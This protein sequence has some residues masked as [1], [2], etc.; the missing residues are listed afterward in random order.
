M[1]DEA[2]FRQTNGSETALKYT[3]RSLLHIVSSEFHYAACDTSNGAFAS[4][5]KRGRVSR[6]CGSVVAESIRI[7]ALHRTAVDPT[8]YHK[9]RV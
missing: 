4:C 8:P 7:G 2:Q 5:G 6:W 9:R 3:L 1:D